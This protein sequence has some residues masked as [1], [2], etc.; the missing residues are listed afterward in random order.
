MQQS[1][2]Q[3]HDAFID[4]Q[5]PQLSCCFS[6]SPRDLSF[7]EPRAA[8]P[9]ILSQHTSHNSTDAAKLFSDPRFSSI[10]LYR[11]LSRRKVPYSDL[12][13]LARLNSEYG[14]MAR[15]QMV[16]ATPR[17]AGNQAS[18][19]GL[20][21]EYGQGLNELDFLDSQDEIREETLAMIPKRFPQVKLVKVLQ[22]T[23]DQPTVWIRQHIA[24]TLL[25]SNTVINAF[26]LLVD[27]IRIY[28]AG[29][30][31]Q[32]F[33]SKWAQ[34]LSTF[35]THIKKHWNGVCMT[36]RFFRL[37]SMLL[38][39]RRLR[40]FD[41]EGVFSIRVTVMITMEDMFKE[42]NSD[43]PIDQ[44]EFDEI[45]EF[46]TQSN[47]V[48]KV[49][50]N[51]NLLQSTLNDSMF[52]QLLDSLRRTPCPSDII[53]Y[54]FSG[55]VVTWDKGA[56]RFPTLEREALRQPYQ[57]HL[58]SSKL[59]I[60]GDVWDN[61]VSNLQRFNARSF[62]T[63]HQASRVDGLY[64]K[65]SIRHFKWFTTGNMVNPNT[66]RFLHIELQNG[67]IRKLTKC[68]FFPLFNNLLILSV[69][70]NDQETNAESLAAFLDLFGSS[71]QKLQAF[72][73]FQRVSGRD[74]KRGV[75]TD[76]AFVKKMTGL[77]CIDIYA[78]N[79]RLDSSNFT[80]HIKQLRYLRAL[81][82]EMEVISSY[83]S[84]EPKEED[85]DSNDRSRNRQNLRLQSEI[86]QCVPWLRLINICS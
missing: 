50:V 16:C 8:S 19:E 60:Q 58:Y 59:L 56:V 23:A 34:I 39:L 10:V 18:L 85:V 82:L 69:E 14:G 36:F 5:Q 74:D 9:Q 42:F 27:S 15:E 75:F 72:W 53:H 67:Q 55:Y 24:Q 38:I 70:S 44:E 49:V 77:R 2:H 7:L 76:L 22:H 31:G 57:K 30:H 3:E 47:I 21:E 78:S 43:K 65:S 11:I 66:V 1:T 64:L 41:E 28:D 71:L 61:K 83:P 86:A 13:G 81:S 46:M 37:K 54:R 73:F 68:N 25:R 52:I 12:C 17:F 33:V 79:W 63:S 35:V 29:P 40:E 4:N 45:R 62:L 48:G 6:L 84:I 80:R 26:L 51:T 32:G 20:A